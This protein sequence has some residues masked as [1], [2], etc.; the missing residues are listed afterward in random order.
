VL[1]P[2]GAETTPAAAGVDAVFLVTTPGTEDAQ[3]LVKTASALLGEGATIVPLRAAE[4]IA[5]T[6]PDLSEM[7]LPPNAL[8]LFPEEEVKT[9]GVSYRLV[10]AGTLDRAIVSHLTELLFRMRAAV[11]E[12]E[13]AI[14]LMQPPDNDTAMTARLPNHRGTI[15]YLNR[16]QV[17]FMTR[18]GDWIWLGLFAGGGVT[19]LFGWLAQML[20]RKR[21]EAIDGVLDRLLRILS[22]ARQSN[23]ADKLNDLALEIDG[24]LASAIH[25]ARH[26]TTNTHTMGSLIVALDG[27][28]AA[29]ADRRRE[30][31]SE[32][33]EVAPRR[34]SRRSA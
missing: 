20:A 26:H 3:R 5:R 28:R 8:G 18:Y 14:N 13:P 15:D 6:L 31:V 4:I 19:S 29:V 16:E 12:R 17:T 24:L 22:E 33:L 25:F 34:A 27:A 2:N 7:T 23:S 30:L 10:A 1:A 32:A 9:M 11:A 21:R